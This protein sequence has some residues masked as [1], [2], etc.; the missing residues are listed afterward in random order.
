MGKK[1]LN[2]KEAVDSLKMEKQKNEEYVKNIQLLRKSNGELIQIVEIMKKSLEKTNDELKFY[3]KI[4]ENLY[5]YQDRVQFL[6]R[7]IERLKKENQ[8]YAYLVSKLLESD[9]KC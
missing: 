2:Y 3:D 7:K 9:K 4:L 8:E 6:D 5:C 1:E